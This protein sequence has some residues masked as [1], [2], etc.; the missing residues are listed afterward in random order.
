MLFRSNIE[1]LGQPP[2]PL[3]EYYPGDAYVDW[4]AMDGFNW[5]TAT[6]ET[7]WNTF[8]QV[9]NQTYNHILS[10]TAN[11]PLM[12]AEIGCVEQG[13]DKAN[14][15]TD[16]YSVE[17][18]NFPAIKAMVW[19]D[20]HTQQDWRI[21]SSETATRAFSQAIQSPIFAANIFAN[22]NGG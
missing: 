22:Y 11:K 17:L 9:F 6:K 13:G 4:T 5:G 12:I 3:S 21:E 19:F 2:F 8:A 16:A 18:N 1:F 20:Q 7:V 10:I 14:W 15:I